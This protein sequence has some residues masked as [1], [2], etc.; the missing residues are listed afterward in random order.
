[1]QLHNF[2]KFGHLSGEQQDTIVHFH[3]GLNALIG[4]NDTGKSAIIDAIKLV[5]Q[6][7]SGEYI[8][9]T[10]DDFYISPSGVQATEFRIDCIFEDFTTNEAKN[11]I[12]WLT[13]TKDVVSGKVKYSLSLHYRAWRENGRIFSELK[14][15]NNDDPVSLDGKAREL[16]KCVYLRPLRDA[17]KEMHSGRNSRIS[18]ILYNHPLFSNKE[19]NALVRLL[20]QAN[21]DIEKYFLEEEGKEILGKIRET[22]ERFL[23]SSESSSASLRT[24]EMKLK[25]IL[26]SLS[27][28]APEIQPGLG[29]HNLLFISAELLLLNHDDN[30]GV[31]LALIEELEAH[32]HPQAQL[33]LVNYLQQEYNDS[34]VQVIIST[35]SPVLAS[36]INVKNIILL[37]DANA[38]EL[39]PEQTK[40]AKGDYLFLQRFLDATKSNLFFSKGIIMVEGD[41]ENLLIPTLADI[42]G[43]N[44]EKH[45][46]S[47]VNVGNVGFFRYSRIFIRAD[48]S[49]IDVPISIVTDCDISPVKTGGIVDPRE[50]DI[51][52][53]ITAIEQKYNAGYIKAFVAPNWTLEYSI[54]L[55]ALKFILYESILQAKKIENS[56]QYSLTLAKITEIEK[57]V[58]TQIAKWDSQAPHEIAYEIYNDTLLNKAT[59]SV[60]T[61]AT[62]KAIVAQCLAS[63]LRWN[64]VDINASGE[65]GVS[66]T[67][68]KMFDLELYQTKID[69]GKKTALKAQIEA[70]PYLSYLI[71]AIRHAAGKEN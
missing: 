10:D 44:L 27:L 39:T 33:R 45:G 28:I 67:K 52:T 48:R 6:T 68:D 30:G 12:E 3:K 62:S 4:E 26:E 36:K 66:L 5:L 24:S 50:A 70:D 41:A 8:R 43:I 69:E 31:K 17:S 16:L 57:S 71:K 19:E 18:Q 9:I 56:D 58:A 21:S 35:H 2:R 65:G 25:S 14:A 60:S 29:V 55:S 42:I 13:Y 7:Q 54:A 61:K 32:L 23:D 63:N 11:F 49:T 40:L 22:L 20:V 34:G 15:G 37:K 47:I 51:S 53:A 38:Y 64:I 46:I 59:P 1:M